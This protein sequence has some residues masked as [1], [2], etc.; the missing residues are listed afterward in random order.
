MQV[1]LRY[2]W[3][4]LSWAME[5]AMIVSIALLDYADFALI[6]ALLLGNAI[7]R[8]TA[9][10]SGSCW[11]DLKHKAGFAPGAPMLGMPAAAERPTLAACLQLP[12]GVT[13][14]R[15]GAG[16]DVC[17]GTQG[18]CDARRLSQGEQSRL[19]CTTGSLQHTRSV[20]PTALMVTSRLGQGAAH[21]LRSR[22]LN[23]LHLLSCRACL[24]DTD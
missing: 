20:C 1:M 5:C 4:P 13:R 17:A 8:Y 18:T 14:G 21:A 12:R 7:V 9:A 3:N 22:P 15:S 11:A 2:M 23:Q 16:A 6:L 19:L 24:H 10:A